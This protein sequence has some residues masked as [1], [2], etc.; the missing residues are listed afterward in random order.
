MHDRRRVRA[1]QRV[2]DA[3]NPAE[4][5]QVVGRHAG[6]T[7]AMVDAAVAAAQKT[8]SAWSATPMMDRVALLVRILDGLR[9]R[10][11]FYA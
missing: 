2:P 10:H 9:R 8:F 4:T 3:I 1:G 5:T 11:E 7:A 6:A